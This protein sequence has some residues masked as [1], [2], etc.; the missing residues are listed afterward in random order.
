M[1]L[2]PVFM[3]VGGGRKIKRAYIQSHN[4]GVLG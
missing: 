1:H 3:E 4:P 2:G